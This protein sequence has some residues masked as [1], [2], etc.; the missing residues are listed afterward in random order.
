MQ[1]K[2]KEEPASPALR[3][4]SEIQLF[5]LCDLDSCRYKSDRYCT[6]D[7]L[8]VKFESIKEEDD[9]STLV[10]EDDEECAD[11]E[12]DFDESDESYDEDDE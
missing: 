6:N 2:A 8:L 9:T 3:L 4:C 5:D 1:D 10:Y 7:E 12:D 11:A